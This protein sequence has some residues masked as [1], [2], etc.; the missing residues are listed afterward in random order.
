MKQPM[1]RGIQFPSS[2]AGSGLSFNRVAALANA[3]L[4]QDNM[5]CELCPI[6]IVCIQNIYI[7]DNLFLLPISPLHRRTYNLQLEIDLMQI[8][9]LL[10]HMTKTIVS[11]IYIINISFLLQT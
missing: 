7:I 3:V 9:T 1:A 10:V 8:H 5:P 2:K 4:E 6:T 11:N